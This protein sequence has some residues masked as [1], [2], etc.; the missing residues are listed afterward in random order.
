MA[1]ASNSLPFELFFQVGYK[2][3]KVERFYENEQDFY[4]H[5]EDPSVILVENVE[6]HVQFRSSDENARLY[7]YGL[8]TIPYR[9]VELDDKGEAY[10]FPNE[11]EI[12]LFSKNY[13]PLIPGTYQIRVETEE[14]T[15]FAPFIIRPKQI[16]AEQ[17]DIMKEQLEETI[18]GLSLD[19][20]SKRYTN[21]E[22]FGKSLPPKLLMQFMIITK[23]FSNVMTALSDLY[24]K[25]NFRTRKEYKLARSDRA[26]VV[27]EVTVRHRLRHPELKEFLKVPVRAIDYNLL[28]N[29]WIK[30]I[31]KR[32]ISI[33]NDFVVSVEYYAA[34]LKEELEQ[35][36]PFM[37][38]ESTQNVYKEKS[39]VYG[40]LN[41]YVDRVQRMKIGFQHITSA[42]W[43]E[44]V[45]DKPVY[46]VPYVLTKDSRYRSIYM[47]YQ[48]LQKDELEITLD[49]RYS[50]QCKRTDK[51][52]EMW[53]YVELI[54]ILEEKLN[55]SPVQGW[56]Y[57]LHYTGE[58]ILIPSL[59]AGEKVILEKDDVQLHYIYD[60]VVPLT[61]K[62]TQLF[63]HPLYMRQQYNRPDGRLDV[64]RKGIYCGSIM[65][66]FKYRP[67]HN[68]WENDRINT[69]ARTR[70]MSQLIAYSDSRST[71]L[72]GEDKPKT[73][74]FQRLSPVAKVWAFYPVHTD[75]KEK[76][77][78]SDDHN[79]QL[80]PLSPGQENS[81][82]VDEFEHVLQ[83]LFHD[84]EEFLVSSS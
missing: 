28:E 13:Y 80:I 44:Q 57:N 43:Y 45:E 67:R 42:H 10:I 65:M 14:K 74:S 8:E 38:Q 47:L 4:R 82:V 34:E 1:I 27:D 16:S 83:Q 21:G 40:E 46:T 54:R 11:G 59:P 69:I 84:S 6:L 81:H 79:L 52:Y 29:I 72:Y 70:E 41:H 20:I 63:E 77:T 24:T 66:D 71:F 15:Y 30:H 58:E 76:P 19:F 60:G 64:Y 2:L 23:H 50:Y 75:R 26:N 7:M 56:I 39:K 18:R 3:E 22:K 73:S 62:E 31:I 32:L 36:T 33:L 25:V 9:G 68:F 55:F 61:S 49:S 51:L 12:S 48:E 37:Y 53:G 17:L 5:I 78:S 35:L